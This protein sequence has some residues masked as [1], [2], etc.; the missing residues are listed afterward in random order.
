MSQLR[1]RADVEAQKSSR[2]ETV[3]DIQII[4]RGTNYRGEHMVKAVVRGTDQSITY[5][6][7][8]GQTLTDDVRHLLIG[9]ARRDLEVSSPSATDRQI[10]GRFQAWRDDLE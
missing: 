5:M 6:L 1:R 3:D 10:R 7:E 2:R 9:R 8:E 4:D